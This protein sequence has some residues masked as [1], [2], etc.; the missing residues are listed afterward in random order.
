MWAPVHFQQGKCVLL[1]S[2]TTGP[3]STLPSL[4][5]HLC[6]LSFCLLCFTNIFLYLELC[7]IF[8]LCELFFWTPQSL[9]SQRKERYN[10]TEL[11]NYN[12]RATEIETPLRYESFCFIFLFFAVFGCSLLEICFFNDKQKRRG[13]GK[14]SKRIGTRRS[15][16]KK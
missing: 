8:K 10:L 1:P 11:E 3:K 9:F 12:Q 2:A 15:R 13:S 4:F 14:V 16:R 7:A 6:R 5:L